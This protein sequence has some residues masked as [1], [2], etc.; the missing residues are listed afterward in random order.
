M[1]QRL[2][3]V[4]L[5]LLGGALLAP[6]P[7][8]AQ[9]FNTFDPFAHLLT[10]PAAQTEKLRFERFHFGA[11]LA[12]WDYP[13]ETF[14]GLTLEFEAE[15]SPL[16]TA[17]YFLTRNLSIGG[18]WNP[19]SAR[20]V[21]SIP[22]ASAT[23]AD[24]DAVSWDVHLTYH[25]SGAWG[26]LGRGWSAQLGYSS[27]SYD[28]DVRPEFVDALGFSDDG[29]TDKSGNV[30]LNKSFRIGAPRVGRKPY[31]ITL[32]GSAGYYFSDDY[33]RALSL[34]GGASIQLSRHLSLSGSI[35][36]PDIRENVIRGTIGLTGRF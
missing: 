30:W 8:A 20:F 29:F 32:F 1:F 36:F 26:P 17:D 21:G 23:L 11:Y 34:L 18:W 9:Q 19:V 5:I 31:P 27:D 33:S 6:L 7:A 22:G 24:I 16:L 3:R 14:D 10:E 25:F 13:S 2:I 15:P 4:S 28:V 35:W 12:L